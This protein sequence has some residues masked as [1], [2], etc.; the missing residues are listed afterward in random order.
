VPSHGYYDKNDTINFIDLTVKSKRVEDIITKAEEETIQP[1]MT[2]TV[3]QSD[4]VKQQVAAKENGDEIIF[5]V[6]FITSPVKIPIGSPKLKSIKDVS[7]YIEKDL[8]KYTTG[9]NSDF[10]K[11]IKYCEE[12]KSLGFSDAFVVAFR[13]NQRISIKEAKQILNK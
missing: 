5:K 6:Q 11:S 3:K 10:A 8:Y 13:A 9:A 12:V 4:S 7:Y 2:D 1:F